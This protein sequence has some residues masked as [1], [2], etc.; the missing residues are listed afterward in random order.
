M[1]ACTYVG[2]LEPT[3]LLRK[4]DYHQNMH[5]IIIVYYCK[6][7]S[8]LIELYIR[9]LHIIHLISAYAVLQST[10]KLLFSLFKVIICIC[11]MY[12]VSPEFPCLCMTLYI[13][14]Y[15]CT[16]LRS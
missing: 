6:G 14:A 4:V 2:I 5:I 1:S 15:V 13:A 8:L 9:T 12:V 7:W 10:P 16:Y 11:C 3:L